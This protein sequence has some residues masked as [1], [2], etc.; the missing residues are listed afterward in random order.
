MSFLKLLEILTLKLVKLVKMFWISILIIFILIIKKKGE[1]QLDSIWNIIKASGYDV[2]DDLVKG[3]YKG[4][5][6][7]K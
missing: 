7:C 5:C 2:K 3:C 1:L 4:G 6:D